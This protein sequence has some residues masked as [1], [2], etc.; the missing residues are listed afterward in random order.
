MRRR[1]AVQTH[2]LTMAFPACC[3]GSAHAAWPRPGVRLVVTALTAVQPLRD[4]SACSSGD[5]TRDDLAGVAWL[6]AVAP[7]TVPQQDAGS[8]G[9]MH[10]QVMEGRSTSRW[11]MRM[12][13]RFLNLI[14]LRAAAGAVG[15]AGVGGLAAGPQ[16]QAALHLHRAVHRCARALVRLAWLFTIAARR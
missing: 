5:T 13:G 16:G 2:G 8:S 9:S 6:F 1:L 11:I 3:S 4:R 7:G 10:S 12:P 15:A 14:L